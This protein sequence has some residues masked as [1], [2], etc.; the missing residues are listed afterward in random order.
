MTHTASDIA[1]CSIAHTCTL[2]HTYMHP[3]MRMRVTIYTN[4]HHAC[5]HACNHT[6]TTTTTAHLQ[7]H[8]QHMIYMHHI[9]TP[10]YLMLPNC[11]RPLARPPPNTQSLTHTPP[12][13]HYSHNVHTTTPTTTS[14]DLSSYYCSSSCFQASCCACR[15]CVA[16]STAACAMRQYN[17]PPE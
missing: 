3:H 11:A 12:P 4:T 15:H 13:L 17:L 2:S 5:M 10:L 16:L 6:T 9:I 8:T 1:A 14:S 7:L